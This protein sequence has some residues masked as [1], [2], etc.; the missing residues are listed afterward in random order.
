MN[1]NSSLIWS[2]CLA[3]ITDHS[4]ATETT[5]YDICPDFCHDNGLAAYAFSDGICF[6]C[7]KG[8]FEIGAPLL[9][10]T[11][12][13]G[14]LPR[15]TDISRWRTSDSAQQIV[16]VHDLRNRGRLWAGIQDRF[17]FCE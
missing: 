10:K 16:A 13:R 17:S 2:H 14:L 9:S 8:V 3:V 4:F 12:S 1:A 11:D 15:S 6:L 5:H 7:R